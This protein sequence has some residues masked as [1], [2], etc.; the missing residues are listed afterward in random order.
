MDE[1][2]EGE[3]EIEEKRTKRRKTI[4]QNLVHYFL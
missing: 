1:D 2:E 4:S 3:D